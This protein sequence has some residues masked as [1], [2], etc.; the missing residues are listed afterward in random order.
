MVSSAR[1]RPVA[2]KHYPVAATH[3]EFGNLLQRLHN[4]KAIYARMRML[5][6]KNT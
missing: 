4:W 3:Y 6:G 2:A 1:H 5:A